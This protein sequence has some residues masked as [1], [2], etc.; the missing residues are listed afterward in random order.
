M[1]FGDSSANELRSYYDGNL[2]VIKVPTY[3]INWADLDNAIIGAMKTSEGIVANYK[4]AIDEVAIFNRVLSDS[5]IQEFYQNGL[6]GFGYCDKCSSGY[7]SLDY[8]GASWNNAFDVNN[9]GVISGR[10]TDM[11]GG[12]HGFIYHRRH[13]FTSLDYPSA[14]WTHVFGINKMG[15][16]VGRWDT[17]S[18][19]GDDPKQGHGFLYN[20]NTYT[21]L[22]TS[23]DF[24]TAKWT[25]AHGLND[26]GMVVGRYND[27]LDKGHGFIATSCE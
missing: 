4:G 6:K 22:D 23:L 7:V 9:S 18:Y 3:P 26:H 25:F 14:L 8:P 19:T 16:V 11:A 10:Y 20:S 12:E 15:N 24:P 13:S 1:S 21:F 2:D 27:A 5:E 17:D